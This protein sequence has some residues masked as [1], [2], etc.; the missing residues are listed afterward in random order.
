MVKDTIEILDS[1]ASRSVP[2]IFLVLGVIA[3]A[4]SGVEILEKNE[5]MKMNVMRLLLGLG[6]LLVIVAVVVTVYPKLNPEDPDQPS[7]SRTY[8]RF[9][10]VAVTIADGWLQITMSQETYGQGASNPCNNSRVVML[11]DHKYSS[12]YL[13]LAQQALISNK[14]LA[15]GMSGRCRTEH[16]WNEIQTL[17]LV[18][19]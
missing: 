13:D 7:T 17:I 19:N 16:N 4:F 18:E 3:I 12:H 1:I 2:E 14:R 11:D 15:V 8:V 6:V 5:A 9:H 10:P